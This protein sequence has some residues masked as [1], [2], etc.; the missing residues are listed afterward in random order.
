MCFGDQWVILLCLVLIG[1][2]NE[3]F[4]D[5]VCFFVCLV[6]QQQC[7]QFLG[8]GF[9]WQLVCDDLCELYCVVGEVLICF[10]VFVGDEVGFVVYYG[11]DCQDDVEV[12]GLF[13]FFGD[14]QGD[15]GG[16]DFLFSLYDL[17]CDC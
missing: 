14:L 1:Q 8:F 2:Q 10:C 12:C 17:L 6:E 4:I 9:V 15:V 13:G 7:E 3:F 5:G 16:I 11:D